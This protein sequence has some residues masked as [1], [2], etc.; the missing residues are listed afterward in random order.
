MN[1]CSLVSKQTGHPI[2]KASLY[3]TATKQ[4]ITKLR[5]L[6]LKIKHVNYLK[7]S[8]SIDPIVCFI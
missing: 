4:Q 3:N 7:S 1:L 6:V 5:F 8:H 2:I